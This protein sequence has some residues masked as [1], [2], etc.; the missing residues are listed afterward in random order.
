MDN[1]SNIHVN[2]N[3]SEANIE[4]S[5]SPS[6]LGYTNP[7]LHRRIDLDP[8]I[9]PGQEYAFIYR[10]KDGVPYKQDITLSIW[11]GL[12]SYRTTETITHDE[13]ST[14]CEIP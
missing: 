13:E 14:T 3:D 4:Y 2:S 1:D 6:E 12:H 10:D 9:E 5:S 11:D 8:I 7:N